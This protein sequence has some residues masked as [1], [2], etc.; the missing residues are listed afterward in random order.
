[1]REPGI[2]VAA[3][4]TVLLKPGDDGWRMVTRRRFER[5]REVPLLIPAVA[6]DVE[7]LLEPG[8]PKWLHPYLPHLYDW[9]DFFEF[10]FPLW[11]RVAEETGGPILELACGTGRVMRELARAGH[12]VTGVD[13]SQ[14]MIDRGIEKLADEP[15]DVRARI[16]WHR[17]DMSS[18][19]IDRRFRL[20]YIA[21]NS[22]HYMD[23][24]D[25][26]GPDELRR[27]TVATLFEHLEPG[28]RAVI[29]NVA[30]LERKEGEKTFPAPC[31]LLHGLGVNPN[32][33]LYTAEYMGLFTDGDTGQRYDGPWRFVEH[34]EDGT[35]RAIEFA[36]P[37]EDPGEIPLPERAT[38]MT[39]A[40]T[41][42]MLE[43][44]GFVDVD[45]RSAPDL[46][47]ISDH[48]WT[49]V[50]LARKP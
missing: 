42:A 21:A 28:G 25:D 27:R 33:G 44:A 1:M 6:P 19:S 37:P 47:P 10:D 31:L 32:T 35:K 16:E 39:R 36:P 4:D 38:S 5:G 15:E 45:V 8:E 30:P 26:A 18:W 11:L 13:I 48:A 24:T 50:F 7:Y 41:V 14:A 22:L 40:E 29:S 49:A 43:A 20:G 46:E 3:G 12:R 17:G 2:E 9:Y 34:R 23:S